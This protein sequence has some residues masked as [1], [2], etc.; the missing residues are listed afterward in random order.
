[1]ARFSYS[2]LFFAFML[3]VFLS[4][5]GFT[6]LLLHRSCSCGFGREPALNEI[7][8]ALNIFIVAIGV[9]VTGLVVSILRDRYG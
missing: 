6:L 1:M 7:E 3:G 5:V 9:W 2:G 8:T 4:L